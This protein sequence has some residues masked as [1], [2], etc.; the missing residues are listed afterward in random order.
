MLAESPT[1]EI[2]QSLRDALAAAEPGLDDPRAFSDTSTG[3]HELLVELAG[4]QTLSL[5]ASILAE[6]LRENTQRVVHSRSQLPSQPRNARKAHRAHEKLVELVEAGDPA[7]AEELWRAHI[8][9]TTPFLL[10]TLP[11]D[12]VLSLHD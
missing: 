10:R 11:S 6:I 5:F 9:A 1:P 3:F 12:T 8:E 7:G 4:S 2:V